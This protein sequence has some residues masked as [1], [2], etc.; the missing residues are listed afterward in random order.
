MAANILDDLRIINYE[1]PSWVRLR[2][3]TADTNV[4][5]SGPTHRI[6]TLGLIS[7]L[8]ISLFISLW[9]VLMLTPD[10]LIPSESPT[11]TPISSWITMICI[12]S[13]IIAYAAL[14][15]YKCWYRRYHSYYAISEE[16]VW[17]SLPK[18]LFSCP[19][20]KAI[21]VDLFSQ[22]SR[23]GNIGFLYS[24]EDIPPSLTDESGE[25]MTT[26]YIKGIREAYTLFQRVKQLHS[27]QRATLD[28]N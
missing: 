16:H 25:R 19:I 3:A 14:K 24:P 20:A 7:P 10:L 4:L 13:G 2:E 28:N 11:P 21:K 22:N 27:K 15:I 18:E 9:F 8:F 23:Y 5:W 12:V 26:I 6:W 17:V 1:S